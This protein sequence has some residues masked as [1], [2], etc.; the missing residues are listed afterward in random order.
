M[1]MTYFESRYQELREEIREACLNHC[2]GM[3]KI[4]KRMP[5]PE[6]ADCVLCGDERQAYRCDACGQVVCTSCFPMVFFYRVMNADPIEYK[7]PFCL[8]CFASFPRVSITE[9]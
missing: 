7:C 3:R 9:A 5:P 4:A 1:T 6:V 8:G 2:R